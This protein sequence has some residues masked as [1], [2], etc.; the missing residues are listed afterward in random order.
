MKKNLIQ[1]NKKLQQQIELLTN[2]I[3]E[4]ENNLKFQNEE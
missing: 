1:S 2:K 4:L 3:F